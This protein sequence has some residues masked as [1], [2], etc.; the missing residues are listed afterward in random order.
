MLALAI[1]RSIWG[2]HFHSWHCLLC[3]L[4]LKSF[5][6]EPLPIAQ[7]VGLGLVLVGVTLSALARLMLCTL[8]NVDV[9][10]A[11]LSKRSI[12]TSRSGRSNL[13]VLPVG[14]S[15]PRA[16]GFRCSR[17]ILPTPL[18]EWIPRIL[19]N[20][21]HWRPATSG[22]SRATNSSSVS[23]TNSFR[24][25]AD[26]LKSAAVP[27]QCFVKWPAP[28]NGNGL[29]GPNCILPGFLTREY[30]CHRKWNLCK[31]MS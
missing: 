9:L 4:L 6:G 2:M 24:K 18:V 11:I 14:T 30:V 22:L 5:P 16:M 29:S 25:H 12:R 8:P 19:T 28:A 1:Q 3:C 31:W 13:D 15:L 21:P 10:P 7:F 17:R 27:E 20:L 23:R 26:S